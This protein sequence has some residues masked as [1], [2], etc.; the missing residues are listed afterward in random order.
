MA[1]GGGIIAEAEATRFAFVVVEKNRPRKLLSWMLGSSSSNGFDG[2]CRRRSC[3]CRGR[4][5][6]VADEASAVAGGGG[7]GG[8]GGRGGKI[9]RDV[10][11]DLLQSMSEARDD[12]IMTFVGG[13][14][15][16]VGGSSSVANNYNMDD[17]PIINVL[18]RGRRVLQP[19]ALLGGWDGGEG[20]APL[21]MEDYHNLSLGTYCGLPPVGWVHI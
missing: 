12:D 3:C 18:S 17:G 2:R 4:D 7:G 21:A 16:K 1:G 6:V 8:G 9:W 14:A 11:V 20:Q 19:A 10:V 15:G 5:D 13:E